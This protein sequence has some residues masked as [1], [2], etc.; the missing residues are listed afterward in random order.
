MALDRQKQLQQAERLLKQGKVQ[1]ALLELERLAESAPRDV[2][3]LNRIG[4][5]LAKVGR[6][7]EAV[8]FYLK[9]AEQFTS[10][11]F[12]HKAVAIHKKI[13]RL[14]P[15]HVAAL[16]Q[17]GDLYYQQ[18]LPGEARTHL[19]RA[20]DQY[21][22]QRNFSKA[23]EVYERLVAAEPDEPRHRARLA[24]AR[25]AEGESPR[26]GTELLELAD[27]LFASGRAK[28]AEQTYRRAAELLP[29]RDEAIV[30]LV[31]CVAEQGRAPEA[32]ALLDK[33]DREHAGS[34]VLL[35]ERVLRYEIAGRA[36]DVLHLLELP[37]ARQIDD[38]V[39]GH[40]FRH[41]R[42]RGTLGALWE[43]MDPVFER[44]SGNGHRQRICSLLESLVEIE[45]GGHVPALER[46]YRE[47]K[48]QDER[49]AMRST[50]A[51]LVRACRSGG[52]ADDAE[53]WQA[54][55]LE[56]D[57]SGAIGADSAAETA[58]GMVELPTDEA[59]P[60]PEPA[61]SGAAPEPSGAA[62][63]AADVEAPAV[64]LN[65]GDEE[66]VAGRLTQTEI[67]EKYGLREQAL[68]QVHEVA[69][70]FPGHVPTQEKRVELLREAS[71]P[72]A[73]QEG[74]VA[75]A[76]ARRA[77]GDLDAARRACAEARSIAPFARATVELLARLGLD[78]RATRP[79]AAPPLS[80]AVPL[81][82]V[83][84]APAAPPRAAA[85]A[86]VAAP[87]AP[88]RSAPSDIPLSAARDGAVL[89]DLDAMD[90]EDA[91]EIAAPAAPFAAPVAEIEE[92]ELVAG[93]ADGETLVVRA[94]A[95]VAAPLS[96]AAAEGFDLDLNPS[97]DDDL[98]AITAALES[99]L[100]ADAA[101]P[102]VAEPE[103]EQS[104]EQ[105]FAAFREHVDREVGSEDY[106]THYDLGI[107]YKEMGLLDEAI[108][109]FEHAVN[110]PDI[111]R[112]AYSMLA[113]CHRERDEMDAAARC[114]RR[115]I[116]SGGGDGESR[117]SLR[118][119]LAEVLLHAGDPQGALLEFRDLL[120]ADPSFRDVRDRVAELARTMPERP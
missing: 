74:L 33:A 51:R 39:F 96:D 81:S 60:D 46:L 106:R 8:R 32:L 11:G 57:P 91:G 117:N 114:Y 97:D 26:A 14:A 15:N 52:R 23:R 102:L 19:L 22:H 25:A 13:L 70:K 119:E 88:V 87:A 38:A 105:V 62:P 86:P 1:P 75:L 27:S 116:A 65:R 80:K 66:Y 120:D 30:G 6:R 31:R 34:V 85:P 103:S 115:A 63:L 43:R 113:L 40:V 58:V 73:L 28:E 5:L 7:E 50:L 12:L 100:F 35:G 45:A 82:P 99:E 93:P 36:R 53:R 111:S 37:H 109:A 41:H 59:W 90:E 42:D 24:E 83:R 20:A 71:R 4:D 84:P 78:E 76:I 3:T 21:L 104:L 72:H 112:E 61:S 55:L 49:D 17:L 18:R 79:A 54:T 2:L 107:A 29:G 77:V 10:S 44:W 108:G 118:Y 16:T 101:E 67:L 56:L 48:A 110:S 69:A 89:I 92:P 95:S 9:I 68:Q 98:S 94:P 47:Q 64:P